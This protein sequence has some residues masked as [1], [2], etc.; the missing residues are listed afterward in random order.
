LGWWILRTSAEEWTAVVHC[1]SH[2]SYDFVQDLCDLSRVTFECHSF[3]KVPAALQRYWQRNEPLSHAKNL[4]LFVY[5][6]FIILSQSP[7]NQWPKPTRTEE[8][9]AIHGAYDTLRAHL[10]SAVGR[11]KR[12]WLGACVRSSP[13]WLRNVIVSCLLLVRPW[14]G[15]IT[16]RH[17]R[18]WTMNEGT[19]GS[20]IG[21]ARQL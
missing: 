21:E 15:V 14:T 3:L 11:V 2:F 9:F 5:F 18:R 16:M 19:M 6:I 4:H 10:F 13:R 1:D 12:L 17:S 20:C 7:T 8:L